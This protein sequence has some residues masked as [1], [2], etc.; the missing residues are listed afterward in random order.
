MN[1]TAWR[2]FHT[3][4]C[5]AGFGW[6]SYYRYACCIGHRMLLLCSGDRT[7]QEND[8]NCFF[9]QWPISLLKS[10]T[11]VNWSVNPTSQQALVWKGLDSHWMPWF[12][13]CSLYNFAP[14]L[15]HRK[16][17]DTW[18]NRT[19][20]WVIFRSEKYNAFCLFTS[21]QVSQIISLNQR[22][23]LKHFP[24]S[25]DYR[26]ALMRTPYLGLFA[27]SHGRNFTMNFF[28][29]RCRT[30]PHTPLPLPF[31]HW[32]LSQFFFQRNL[33]D[34]ELNCCRVTHWTSGFCWKHQNV[35][36]WSVLMWKGLQLL[37]WP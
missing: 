28:F 34:G 30:K 37:C 19:F 29:T 13:C 26:F 4:T 36:C 25:L 32:T 5:W 7:T 35:H 20:L 14:C 1:R 33:T 21:I 18:S 27:K 16:W 11:R 22:K 3:K 8:W 6:K 31:S 23:K 17:I 10:N 15:A 12:S 9:L 24:F 2:T